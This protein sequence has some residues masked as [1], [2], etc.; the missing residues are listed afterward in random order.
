[1][2]AKLGLVV[3]LGALLAAGNGF[4]AGNEEEEKETAAGNADAKKR[5][6]EG[7]ERYAHGDY[8]G[9]V[10]SFKAAI[11]ADPKL[12]GPYRNLGLAYR[13]L[14]RCADALPMYEKYLEL[15]PESRFTDRVRREIDLCRAKLGQTSETEV[16]KAAISRHLRN[17]LNA[18]L[19]RN[20]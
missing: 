6:V 3:T 11:A 20:I 14:N 2:R 16:R 7:N 4:A 8:D 12:P 18:K 19:R 9:A 1:M 17:A 13:A 10:E 15:K 5:F